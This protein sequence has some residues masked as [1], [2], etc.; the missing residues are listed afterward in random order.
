M[1]ELETL[2]MA[3]ER[4]PT[5]DA[6][7]WLYQLRRNREGECRG[8]SRYR[9]S[10]LKAIRK[11]YFEEL[12]DAVLRKDWNGEDGFESRGVR[13]EQFN[14]DEGGLYWL[15]TSDSRISGAW[16]HLHGAKIADERSW[17]KGLDDENRESVNGVGISFGTGNNAVEFL[18]AR[19]PVKKLKFVFGCIGEVLTELPKVVI[20]L[21]MALD[22]VVMGGRVYFFNPNLRKQLWSREAETRDVWGKIAREVDRTKL[23]NPDLF[24]QVALKGMNRRRMA[25]LD[26]ERVDALLDGRRGRKLAEQ[27]KVKVA[28]GQ[29]ATDE[30]ADVERLVKLITKH[31]MMDPF[32]EQPVEVARSKTWE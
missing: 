19:P 6:R 16:T 4:L 20:T 9:L 15:S 25:N 31:G 32:Q 21:P 23:S 24:E 27:F 1:A 7:I 26:R 17:L 3:I 28:N 2:R 8:A 11:R 12:A 14:G 22:A 18:A 13:V 5:E 30:P 29:L 10:L